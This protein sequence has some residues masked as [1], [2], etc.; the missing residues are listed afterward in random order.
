MACVITGYIRVVALGLLQINGG[1]GNALYG[2]QG[3]Y[4]MLTAALAAHAG[5]LVSMRHGV[6]YKFVF[7][8][9]PV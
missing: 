2:G 9:S 5:N 7:N 8:K 3:M 1:F 6:Q 4:N